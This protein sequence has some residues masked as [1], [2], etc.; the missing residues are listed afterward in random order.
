MPEDASSD[1]LLCNS[2][3]E[4][5]ETEADEQTYEKKQALG[6]LREKVIQYR[7]GLETFG[8]AFGYQLPTLKAGASITEIKATWKEAESSAPVK[9][10]RTRSGMCL[11]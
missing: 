6:A 9:R 8:V 2:C 1:E 11:G 7:Q 5:S 10:S 3:Y 4:A